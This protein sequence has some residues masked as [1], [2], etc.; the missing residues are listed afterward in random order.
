LTTPTV[1]PH[2]DA[3][4]AALAGATPPMTVYLGGAPQSAVPPYCV[5][6]PDVGAPVRASL[7]DD[8]VDFTGVVQVTC[9]GATAEQALNYS[10]RTHAALSGPLTVSGRTAWRPEALDGTP[11]QRDDD[12][13]PPLFYAAARYRLRSTPQ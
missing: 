3:V 7:A 8:R 12:V 11:V 5:L 13:T 6:Y 4:T 2:V 10:D 1:L 9:V